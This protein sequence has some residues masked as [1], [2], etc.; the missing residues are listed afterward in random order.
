MRD[1]R[2]VEMLQEDG[3]GGA[4]QVRDVNPI[5][6][7][8]AVGLTPA[9]NG[10][11]G[12]RSRPRNDADHSHGSPDPVSGPGA[13]MLEFMPRPPGGFIPGIGKDSVFQSRFPDF[14]EFILPDKGA[15]FQFPLE[16][17]NQFPAAALACSA[18][19]LPTRPA[20]MMASVVRAGKLP[21]SSML[22]K[23]STEI[24]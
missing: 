19:S 5:H 6:I 23:S 21:P 9:V 24:G 20:A 4:E 14:G 17:R 22:R 12:D 18:R 7:R 2:V 8:H 15:P 1:D 10:Q 16:R 3:S 13:V 11:P